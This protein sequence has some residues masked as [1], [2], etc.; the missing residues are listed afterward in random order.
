MK[1]S[2]LTVMFSCCIWGWV[3]WAGNFCELW[4]PLVQPEWSFCLKPLFLFAFHLFCKWKLIKWWNSVLHKVYLLSATL[5][6]EYSKVKHNEEHTPVNMWV[7]MKW[8]CSESDV[9]CISLSLH[10]SNNCP[11]T[12]YC[13]SCSEVKEL[14]SLPCCWPAAALELG[15]PGTFCYYKIP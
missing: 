12:G 3:G 4:M 9:L 7:D 11:N 15:A 8:L 5:V 13:K 14:A 10:I 1:T 6:M 2:K